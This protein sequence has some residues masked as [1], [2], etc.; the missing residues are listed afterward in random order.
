[1]T[2]KK[3][4]HY[5]PVSYLKAF[6]A[7]DGM[8]TVYRKDAPH[9]PHR[10]RPEEIAFHKY[11]YAQPLEDGGLDTNSLEDCFSELES[12]WPVIV[13]RIVSGEQVNDCLKDICGFVALQRARVPAAR[14][15]AE[16]IQ[17]ATVLAVGRRLETQGKLPPPPKNFPNIMDHLQVPIDPHSSIHS[18]VDIVNAMGEVLDRVG[19]LVLRNNTD[20]EFVTSDN[21]VVYFDPAINRDKLRPYTISPESDVVL[22]MPISPS[23]VLF[24]ASK[25]K[26]RFSERGIEYSSISDRGKI[27]PINEMIIRFGYSAIFSRS[28]PDE[29]II[30]AHA[31]L[32]PVTKID[33]RKTEERELV[34]VQ[35]VFGERETKPKWKRRRRGKL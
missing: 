32:S 18:M 6:C 12:T 7:Q 9:S 29:Q 1:M 3:R 27:A 20:V 19:L 24:G 28:R 8:I 25:D 21:P 2:I 5:V 15:A 22:M 35:S 14:D 23:L 33:H 4:H 31:A 26:P 16:R 17:A 11:Y 13:Q 34:I 30:Q 10:H